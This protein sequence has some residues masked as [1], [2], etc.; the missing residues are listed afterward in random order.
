[1][2]SAA[3]HHFPWTKSNLTFPM[4][5]LA[6]HSFRIF[7]TMLLYILMRLCAFHNEI[8]HCYSDNFAQDNAITGLFVRCWM[9]GKMALCDIYIFSKTH[10]QALDF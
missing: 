1:M 5:F 6:I 8:W 2:E 3:L 4:S 10:H 7:L 9:V